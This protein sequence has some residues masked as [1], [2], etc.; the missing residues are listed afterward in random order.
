MS[1]AVKVQ[2]ESRPAVPRDAAVV[3]LVRA[4]GEDA[5]GPE[6]FG[7]RRSE[8]MAF[9][10]GFYAFP[11]GQRDEADSEVEVEGAADRET[12]TMIACDARGVFEALG[13]VGARG[14]G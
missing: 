7:A 3:V 10:P 12:A 11:G 1:E 8:R 4:G 9:Q 2:D 5:R 6:V 13:G 14:A